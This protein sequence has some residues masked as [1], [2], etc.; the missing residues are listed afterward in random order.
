[1]VNIVKKVSKFEGEREDMNY[2]KPIQKKD[3]GTVLSGCLAQ[4]ISN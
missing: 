4:S 3:I 2:F 1:M